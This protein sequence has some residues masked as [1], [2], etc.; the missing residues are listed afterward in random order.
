MDLY[1]VLVGLHIVCNC[2]APGAIGSGLGLVGAVSV[3]SDWVKWKV[4][5]ASSISVRQHVK[6]SEQVRP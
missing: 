3:Y 5:S 1:Y 4:C 2:Q 6:L